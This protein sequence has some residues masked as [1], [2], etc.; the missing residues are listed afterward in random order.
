VNL[1]NKNIGT[2]GETPMIV[3]CPKG[4]HSRMS[5]VLDTAGLSR[6]NESVMRDTLDSLTETYSPCREGSL[7]ERRLLKCKKYL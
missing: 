3:G 7:P 4:K 5:S 6:R 2:E 1:W